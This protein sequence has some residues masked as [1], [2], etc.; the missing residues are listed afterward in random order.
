[1]FKKLKKKFDEMYN[2]LKQIVDTMYEISHIKQIALDLAQWA[3]L[4][5]AAIHDLHIQ[6]ENI[7]ARLEP[8]IEEVSAEQIVLNDFRH[9][10]EPFLYKNVTI[11]DSL[12]NAFICTGRLTGFGMIT[13]NH[14]SEIDQDFKTSIK[15]YIIIDTGDANATPQVINVTPEIKIISDTV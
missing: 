1:M 2:M 5:N 13:K 7:E 3:E 14:Y 9:N 12:N 10:V 4:N 6:T 11:F 8:H 15:N